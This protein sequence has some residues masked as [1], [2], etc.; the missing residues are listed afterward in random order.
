MKLAKFF[1]KFQLMLTHKRNKFISFIIMTLFLFPNSTLYTENFQK[2]RFTLE[3]IDANQAFDQQFF[4]ATIGSLIY[5]NLTEEE[6]SFLKKQF[7]TF[8][9][10]LFGSFNNAE[11]SLE[12]EL[13]DFSEK[14]SKIINLMEN[15]IEILRNSTVP[16]IE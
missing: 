11:F 2:L 15:E 13:N 4:E 8:I 7:P 16:N 10:S 12:H 1:L 9:N 6:I 5:I 3:E 14:F